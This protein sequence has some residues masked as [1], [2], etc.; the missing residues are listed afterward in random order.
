MIPVANKGLG[1]D[2]SQIR[3]MWRSWK[4]P[5][6]VWILGGGVDPWIQPLPYPTGTSESTISKPLP[7]GG[8]YVIVSL[9]SKP[10]GKLAMIKTLHMS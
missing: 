8:G 3:K 1:W 9:E 5:G 6:V 4:I 10:V 7:F 2:T